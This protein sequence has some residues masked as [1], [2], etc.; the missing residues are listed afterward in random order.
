MTISDIQ[1]ARLR[2]AGI[3]VLVSSLIAACVALVTLRFWYPGQIG[4]IAGGTKLFLL[5]LGVDVVMGPLLTL[6]VFNVRKPRAELVRDLAVIGVLQLAALGYGLYTLHAARPVAVVLEP[7]RFRVVS[8]QE[9]RL[10]ELPE[11]RPEYRALSLSGPLLLGARASR[12]GEERLK[13]LDLALS[14]YD[15]GQRPSLWQPYAESRADAWSQAQPL[16]A[17]ARRHSERREELVRALATMGVTLE[18]GR[19]LPV[20]ARGDWVAVLKDGGDIAGYAPFDGF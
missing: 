14:G 2:A 18:Q 20:V 10:E 5:I 13:S 4:A 6:I 17:L 9:V 11:A 7:G 1:R 12:T 16:E 8:A 3:H 15:I 19:Y